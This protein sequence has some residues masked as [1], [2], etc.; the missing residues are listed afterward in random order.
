MLKVDRAFLDLKVP[1]LFFR[2]LIK[3]RHVSRFDDL[4]V[5]P[6]FTYAYKIKKLPKYISPFHFELKT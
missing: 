1:R 4:Y 5:L 2:I 6:L 3:C